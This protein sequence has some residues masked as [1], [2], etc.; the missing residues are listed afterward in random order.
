VA[1]ARALVVRPQVLLLDEPLSNLELSLREELRDVIRNLQRESGIT[2]IFVTHDQD[3]A[4]VIADRIALMLADRIHQVGEPRSFFEHPKDEVVAR[5]FGNNNIYS[6]TKSGL[7]VQTAFGALEIAPADLPDGDVKAAIRP[8]AIIIGKNGHNNYPAQLV[9]C[10]YQGSQTYCQF[11][12]N[13]QTLTV[14]TQPY[15]NYNIGDTLTVHLPK[16]RISV[17][18]QNVP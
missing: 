14:A 4:V 11:Q 1:L 6:G 5:F 2:T 9:S 12:I 10:H 17:M 18:P 8:E 15:Q 13:G 16:E 7:Q 3:E